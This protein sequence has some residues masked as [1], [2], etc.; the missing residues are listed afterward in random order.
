MK[1]K[2]VVVVKLNGVYNYQVKF[3]DDINIITGLN[4]SGK[5]TFIKLIWYIISGN[6]ER[7]PAEINVLSAKVITDSYTVSI[8]LT[9]TPDNDNV[10]KG[11]SYKITYKSDKNNRE[12]TIPMSQISANNDLDEINKFVA[13]QAG[14]LFF[15]TYRRVE[16]GSES[17]E[18]NRLFNHRV[19]GEPR[20]ALEVIGTTLDKV[21]KEISVYKHKFVTSIS[22]DDIIELITEKYANIS[23]IN[24]LVQNQLSETII[25]K[26]ESHKTE[27]SRE[28]NAIMQSIKN[29]IETSNSRR[30]KNMMPLTQFS[31]LA[32]DVLGNKK[33]KITRFITLGDERNKE[34]PA[35]L[36]SAGEKQMIGF[37]CYN[38]LYQNIPIIIDE[39]EL[40]LHTDWQRT[41][42]PLLL[43]QHTKNQFIVV[44][45]SP[46]IYSKYRDREIIFNKDRGDTESQDEIDSIST[47]FKH[48]ENE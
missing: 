39:P 5:S 24:N 4:G 9:G 33:V 20:S 15:P 40:S 25:N 41:L 6:L 19:F 48:G 45:H 21:S 37:L 42:F 16:W 1:I 2:E 35:Y 38:A 36:L 26:I 44:T 7:I 30:E 31:E 13:K 43:S 11:R 28:S 27:N 12:V 23:R 14:S 3:H 29:D 47:S 32:G 17:S 34:V 22:V 10:I 18:A 8:E 46:F